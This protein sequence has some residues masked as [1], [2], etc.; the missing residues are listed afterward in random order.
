MTNVDIVK[1][2]YSN[3]A[4]GNVEAV[5]ATFDTDIEWHECVGMLL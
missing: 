5:L 3:F 2:G 4:T 1:Q